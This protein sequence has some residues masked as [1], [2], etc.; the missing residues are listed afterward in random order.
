MLTIENLTYVYSLLGSGLVVGA[1]LGAI[2]F[3]LG[4]AINWIY[5][6]IRHYT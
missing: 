5:S 2:P 3:L 6:L 1:L 4:Y